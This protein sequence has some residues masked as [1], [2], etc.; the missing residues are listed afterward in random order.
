MKKR[1]HHYQP[2]RQIK[3]I[4][5]I[6]GARVQDIECLPCMQSMGFHPHTTHG[7]PIMPEVNP[8]HRQDKEKAQ[9]H[10]GTAQTFLPNKVDTMKGFIQTSLTTKEQIFW[11]Y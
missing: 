1:V 6:L 7:T 9:Y 4:V 11:K 10:G 3:D 5:K 2:F 8:E